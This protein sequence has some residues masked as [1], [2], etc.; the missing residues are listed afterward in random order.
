MKPLLWT[1]GCRC[2]EPM[3]TDAP[4]PGD[5]RGPRLT[6]SRVPCPVDQRT[7]RNSPPSVAVSGETDFSPEE[8]FLGLSFLTFREQINRLSLAP[9][10][11]SHENFRKERFCGLSWSTPKGSRF[12]KL[13]RK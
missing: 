7:S 6:A 8:S 13:W 5:P 1:R 2:M 9:S 12:T 10:E 4:A 3:P 11:T